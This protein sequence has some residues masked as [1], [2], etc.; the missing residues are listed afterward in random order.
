MK[1]GLPKLFENPIVTKSGEERYI[2]WANSEIKRGETTTGIIS[3]GIDIT[4][5]KQ[6]VEALEES[7]QKFRGFME[8][9]PFAISLVNPDGRIDQVNKAFMTLWGISEDDWPK[10]KEEYNLL[11]DKQAMELGVMPL[12]QRAFSG[13]S[14]VLP[15][16]EYD[17]E[18][19]MDSL[20]IDTRSN[21]RS[22]Q[23]RLYPLKNS[24]GDVIKVA[25]MAED[26]TDRRQVE[27][28]MRRLREEYTH[29]ARVSAMGELTASLAHE[30]KQPLA[31]IRSNAQA[32]QRFLTEDKPDIDEIHEI[33]KDIVS[34]NR[35]ADDVIAK[36][37]SLMRKGTLQITELDINE[38]VR[39]ILPL[40]NSHHIGGN[41]R[42]ELQLD[43]SIAHVS[44]DPVQLQQVIL[45]LILNSTEA[46][47]N[48]EVDRRVI[49]VRTSPHDGESVL[50][51]VIDNGPGI[52]DKSISR[53]FEAFYTTKNEGLGMGLAI[54]RTI[55]EEHRGRLWASNNPDRGA[56]FS[57]T[58]PTFNENST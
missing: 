39:D 54:S 56:T 44:G 36:L 47:T 4:E 49:I 50:L 11:K 26:I 14:V 1:G 32:A 16:L 41:I 42:V 38:L 20:G 24:K 30:L 13:E 55:I 53:L 28:E 5:R 3:F 43:E 19:T 9:S 27:E 58:I 25:D 40:I 46:V 23:V 45:N 52:D 8:Q 31:A 34:D 18:N 35:R 48:L 12:I 21:K 7:E 57:F 22:I 17:A 37:R 33:L 29:I 6:A 51:S 10:I 2:S 15:V